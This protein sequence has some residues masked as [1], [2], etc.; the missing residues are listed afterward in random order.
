VSRTIFDTPLLNSL[1]HRLALL[2]LRALGWRLEGRPPSLPKYVLIAAPH[3][4]NWDLPMTLVMAFAYRLS[5]T[6]MG[7]DA[8]FRPPF[9]GFF[10]WLG[11]IAVDRRQS[12][13]LVAR[14]VEELGRSDGL[15]MLIPPEGTRQR[16][17]YWKTGFY[18]IAHGAGVPIALGF[19]DYGRKVGGIGPL[20]VPSGDL[21]A[22]MVG[23][24]AFYA[25]V[26]GKYPGDSGTADTAPPPSVTR[27]A[28]G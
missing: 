5:I 14:S 9:G 18:W 17:R 13:D 3:T 12:T 15:V 1:L 22:D 24:R 25:G 21:E 8:L 19:M 20:V 28:A 2:V 11:G 16:V 27:S 4:S 23:I 6:W 26:T 10:R 7:K